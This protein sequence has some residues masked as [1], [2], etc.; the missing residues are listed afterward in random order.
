MDIQTYH[1]SQ[2]PFVGGTADGLTWWEHLTISSE[3]HPLKAFAI[4]ILSIVPHAGDIKRLFSD[5]GNTQSPRWCNLS[6]S[7]FETL[8]KICTNLN[9]HIHTSKIANNEKTWCHHAHMHIRDQPGININVAKDLEERFT[10]VPLL[11]A[12]SNEDLAGPEAISLNELDALFST[13]GQAVESEELG[14]VG[15]WGVVEGS[16]HSFKELD[17]VDEG[18][19][20]QGIDEVVEVVDHNWRDN[21]GWDVITLMSL[22]GVAQCP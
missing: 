6:V 19:A 1:L 14:S 4:T 16:V 5:L 22:N 17:R 10:W 9:Y 7:T 8:R 18:I 13:V 20:P 2:A 21:G 15:S 3:D 11:L 12:Q